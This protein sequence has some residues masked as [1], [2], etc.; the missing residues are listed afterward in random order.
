MIIY[1]TEYKI[2]IEIEVWRLFRLLTPDMKYR[3]I[4][5]IKAMDLFASHLHLVY[6]HTTT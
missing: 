5:Y 1:K 6:L 3:L 4:D 2:N